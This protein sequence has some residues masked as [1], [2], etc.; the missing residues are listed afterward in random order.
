LFVFIIALCF[1][2]L[3]SAPVALLLGIL[4][5]DKRKAPDWFPGSVVTKYLLQ[6]SIVLMGFGMNLARYE[7]FRNRVLAHG[8]IGYD[9]HRI[10]IVAWLFAEGGPKNGLADFERDGHFGGA[11]LLPY[12]R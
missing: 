6:G 4:F 12:R 11:L 3:T 5:F 1:S 7:N 8:W 9:Y 2:P 10:R